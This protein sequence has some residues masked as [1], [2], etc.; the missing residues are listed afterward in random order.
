MPSVSPSSPVRSGAITA[1]CTMR[2]FGGRD[3]GPRRCENR[4]AVACCKG[5]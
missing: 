4:P 1:L 5:P 3:Q 2:I